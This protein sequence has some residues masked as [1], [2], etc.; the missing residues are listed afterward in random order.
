MCWR[1]RKKKPESSHLS[2]EIASTDERRPREDMREEERNLF[3]VGG[4]RRSERN[5]SV[6]AIRVSR[7][8]RTPRGIKRML[9]SIIHMLCKIRM[10]RSPL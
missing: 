1:D 8:E 5:R 2:I 10:E 7:G 4:D 3:M 6:F 9:R